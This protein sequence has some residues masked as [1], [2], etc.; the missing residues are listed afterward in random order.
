MD[1]YP[2]IEK[3]KPKMFG[4]CFHMFYKYDGQNIRIEWNNKKGF[5]K[6]GSRTQLIDQTNEQFAPAIS[7]FIEK[8]ALPLAIYFRDFHI[9]N[10][11]IFC[12]YWGPNSLAGIHSKEDKDNMNITIID[13][14]LN[15]KGFINP[16]EF[17]LFAEHFKNIPNATAKYLG[18]FQYNNELVEEI[19]IA[20]W[21]VFEGIKEGVVLKKFK[22]NQLIMIKIKTN[23]W[24]NKIKEVHKE[25]AHII[26]ES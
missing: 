24:I 21:D 4:E 13:I 10:A 26:L 3:Y 9:K 23:W 25:N 14:K 5:Y 20:E 2:S 17:I 22:G 16:S 1:S 19:R 18:Y 6:F 11:I 15:K 8:L 7:L 12:E